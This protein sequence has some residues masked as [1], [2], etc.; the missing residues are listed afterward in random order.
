MNVLQDSTSIKLFIIHQKKMSAI[1]KD[2]P[3]N[4]SPLQGTMKIH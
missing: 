3:E 1:D 4:L 2:V